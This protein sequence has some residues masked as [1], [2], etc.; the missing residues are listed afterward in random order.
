MHRRVRF[1]VP[2]SLP[3]DVYISAIEYRPGNRRVVHHMLTYVE[4]KGEA[5]G[6][7]ALAAR[8]FYRT[9]RRRRRRL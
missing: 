5:R 1:V 8:W 9:A 7:A 4:T 3:D 2:T 6:C